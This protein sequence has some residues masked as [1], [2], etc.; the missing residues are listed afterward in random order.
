MKFSIETFK[1]WLTLRGAIIDPPTNEWEVLRVRTCDGV[2][3]IYKNKR[4][5][6]TWPE[7]LLSVRQAFVDK[8]D[9]SLSPDLTV[10]KRLRHTI[11]DLA[12]SD[13]LWCWYCETGFL[14]SESREISIEHLCSVAHG[15]P[16]HPSN[17]VLAC[18][19]CNGEAGTLSIAEKVAMRDRKRGSVYEQTKR[20]AA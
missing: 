14:N 6:E 3:V 17:L 20:G 10:R 2:F 12:A 19:A 8:K 5:D 11:D 15:G 1:T 9:I 7:G 16:N 18:H 13:G 4:G